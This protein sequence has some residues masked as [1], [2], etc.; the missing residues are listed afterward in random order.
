MSKNRVSILLAFVLVGAS[1]AARAQN[2]DEALKLYQGQEYPEA[3]L[4][5]YDVLAN[6][7]NPDRRDQAEIYLA[8]SLKK[9]GFYVPALFYYRDLFQAGAGNRY[10]LNAV[11]GLLEVQQQLHDHLYVPSLVNERFD[12][13][14]FA[15]LDRPKIDQI[16]YLIGELSFRQRKNQD[17]KRFLEYVSESS[18]YYVKARYLLGILE[19]RGNNQEG[20]LPHFKAMIAKI[21]ADTTQVELRGLRNLGLLAAG[22][23]AY[24]LGQYKEA[25]A[26]YAEVPRFSDEWFNAM[27]ENAWAY[28]RAEEY[29][30]ALGELESITSPYFSKRHVPEAYVIRGTTYFVNCQWDRVRGSVEVYKKTYEPMMKELKAYLEAEREAPEYY[31]D[32][33]AGGSG[34]YSVE[35]AREARRSRRFKDF[36]FMLEHM[37]WE[38]ERLKEV[39]TLNGSR[40]AGDIQL[41]IDEQRANLEAAVGRWVRTQLRNQLANLQN[42]QNQ[43]NILDFELT[44]AERQWLEQGQEIL[45]GRR[46][47]LPRPSIPN[48]QWQHWSREREFWKDELGYYRHSLRSECL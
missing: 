38:T 40:L 37:R 3:A 10:Y 24:G 12:P 25:S 22:R 30:R 21:P 15:R 42:F 26:F 2:I 9:M 46:A 28:F 35:L 45:K 27:Y 48:D 32:V 4:A 7:A 5:F 11:E 31:L 20:A 23:A 41:V 19:V 36:H 1:S 34:K 18:P 33:V 13:Q 17:A 29:G 43:I 16:N 39:S 6:D 8:E 47:R 14:A 44:D